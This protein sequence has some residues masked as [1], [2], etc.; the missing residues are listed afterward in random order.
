VNP[1]N[2]RFVIKN[3]VVDLTLPRKIREEMS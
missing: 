1:E 2:I 3:I